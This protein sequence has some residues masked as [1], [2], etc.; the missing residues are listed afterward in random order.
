MKTSTKI[1]LTLGT[2]IILLTHFTLTGIY[3]FQEL[4]VSENVRAISN[5]YTIPFFHQNWK[6]FAPEMPN[7]DC[8]LWVRT[9]ENS[10]WSAPFRMSERG[11][12][13]YSS[14]VTYMEFSIANALANELAANMYWENGKRNL[15]RV[16][17]SLSFGRAVYFAERMCRRHLD[18]QADSLQ[19][20][21]QFHFHER[22]QNS[23]QTTIEFSKIELKK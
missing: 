20:Q 1:L 18:L 6:L 23:Q 16:E 4:P 19:I 21:L 15:T 22:G 14:K 12:F 10:M 2:G 11:N 17:Q 8:F 5:A 3:T 13:G 9:K 7:Y